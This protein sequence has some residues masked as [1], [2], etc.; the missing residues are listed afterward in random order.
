M[1]SLTIQLKKGRGGPDSLACVRADGTRTW[2]RLQPALAVH[3]LV[4]FAVESELELR[5]GFFGLLASGW[6]V[7]TFLDR[8]ARSELPAE[9]VEAEH[10]VGRFWQETWDGSPPDAETFNAALAA[11]EAAR[12]GLVL[13]RPSHAEIARVRARLR[14]LVDR[15]YSLAP[16][17]T[18]ELEFAPEEVRRQPQ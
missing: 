15:W 10:L 9:A 2:E 17:E 1:A 13:R 4:H 3:D 16:G 12:P 18:L 7:T 8:E 5:A 6:S 14:E 11:I